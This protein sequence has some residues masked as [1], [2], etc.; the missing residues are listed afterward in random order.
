MNNWTWVVWEDTKGTNRDDAWAEG[1]EDKELARLMSEWTN[2]WW[3]MTDDGA[4]G[5]MMQ[6]VIKWRSEVMLTTLNFP[7]SGGKGNATAAENLNNNLQHDSVFKS[8][9]EDP[10]PLKHGVSTVHCRFFWK[11]GRGEAAAENRYHSNQSG[12]GQR[13]HITLCCSPAQEWRWNSTLHCS[14]ARPLQSG[15]AAATK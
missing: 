14:E 15:G 3:V 10:D 4:E 12:N 2:V 1:K 7:P 9:C 13:W 11:C 8:V 5:M 6:S